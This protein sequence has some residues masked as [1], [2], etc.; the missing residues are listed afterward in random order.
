MRRSLT[1]A[2]LA[3]V[4]CGQD[5]TV[6]T[7]A[8]FERPG[9]VAFVCV[10]TETS[11]L[12]VRDLC[13]GVTGSTDE[14]YA[15]VGLVTQTAS[16]EVGAIDF[17]VR[18][19]V[20]A[21]PRVP[22]FTFTRVGEFPSAIAVAPEEPGVTYVASFGSRRVE[23]YPTGLFL[24]GA[25]P[26][27]EV[28][29]SVDLSAGPTDLVLAPNA[30]VAYLALPG[31]GT[32]VPVPIQADRSLGDPSGTITPTVPTELPA[33]EAGPASD[34]RFEC[35]PEGETAFLGT[36]PMSDVRTEVLAAGM[37]AQPHRLLV[38]DNPDGTDDELLVADRELPLIYR[39]TI[40]ADGTL[41]EQPP[42]APGV[43]VRDLA[44]SPFVSATATGGVPEGSARYLY[45][46]DD[47]DQSVLVMDFDPD[48]T[49]TSFGAVLPVSFGN[50]QADRLR[51]AGKANALDVIVR[52]YDPESPDYCTA[53]TGDESPLN[54]RGVFLAVGL[55]NGAM[56]I[57]DVV[58]LDGPCRGVQCTPADSPAEEIDQ[59]VYIQRH[60]PRVANFVVEG[61][62][63]L[64]SP[65]LSVD[66]VGRVADTTVG[67]QVIEGM[68]A[69]ECPPGQD[70]IFGE[71]ICAAADPWALRA[72]RW[73]AT[74]EGTI[75][76]TR[77]LARFEAAGGG[78]FD[79]ILED[80]RAVLC[81]RGVLGAQDLVGL[82]QDD[83]EFGY[84]G[85]TLLITTEPPEEKREICAEYFEPEEGSSREREV[86]ELPIRQAFA[87]RVRVDI[88]DSVDQTDFLECY[89]DTAEFVGVSVRLEQAFLVSG[90][91]TGFLHRVVAEDGTDA[92][93]VDAAGQPIDPADPTTYRNGRAFNGR[94]V[95]PDADPPV[96]EPAPYQNPYIA[97]S[98]DAIGI[99]EE[100]QL[101]MNLSG[102]PTP[103]AIPVGARPG[104]ASVITIVEDV[105]YSPVDERLYVLDSN[106]S[107]LVQYQV[108][109][110]QVENVFE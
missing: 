29:G 69:R 6:V 89:A 11:T 61:V 81:E 75:P 44:V 34:Y 15:L 109:E 66:G 107:A 27:A 83:P 72:E 76:G 101:R 106:A 110:F 74:Y 7:P 79:F 23:W 3:I 104:R 39:F 8:T 54:L 19:V 57:V 60:R 38:V 65:V 28:R 67:D 99:N 17:R 37:A 70:Y 82:T 59:F 51:L 105:V 1:I 35:A 55:A 98:F 31:D 12:V 13:E 49:S 40:A 4:A 84:G 30:P 108:A 41:T 53:P 22:G 87:D 97:F 45:A 14:R 94:V 33:P 5:P 85:D 90:A 36:P 88:Q 102:T 9:A 95:D 21:D 52:A 20:D 2:L 96:T 77:E 42:L 68:A 24:G 78:F 32:V 91:Q 92:C 73:T 63:T 50:D 47:T 25:V 71:L 64:G 46:I 103:F 62:S 100:A 26:S 86:I 43:P 18:R 93:R 58:D 48:P 10:D 80:G 16:G 56:Q